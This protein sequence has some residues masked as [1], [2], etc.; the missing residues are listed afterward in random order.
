MISKT[1][2]TAPAADMPS[3]VD[4]ATTPY[5]NGCAKLWISRRIRADEAGMRLRSGWELKK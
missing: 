5:C 2:L 1:D 3:A 4:L